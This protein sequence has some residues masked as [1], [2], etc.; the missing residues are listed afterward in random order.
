MQ[1]ILM[2]YINNIN[3][4]LAKSRTTS[5]MQKSLFLTCFTHYETQEPLKV[6]GKLSEIVVREVEKEE[7][8]SSY[9]GNVG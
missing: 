8:R 6:E 4:G 2:C 9:Y 1:I 5:E 3:T 7:I